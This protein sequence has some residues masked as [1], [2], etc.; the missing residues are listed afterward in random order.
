L[1]WLWLAFCL[2]FFGVGMTEKFVGWCRWQYHNIYS[3]LKE[4][5]IVSI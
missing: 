2:G 4:L 3:L 1:L 5:N